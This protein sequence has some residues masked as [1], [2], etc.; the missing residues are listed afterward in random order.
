MKEFCTGEDSHTVV[1]C[2]EPRAVGEDDRY[3]LRCT[4][5]GKEETD[6][7]RRPRQTSM[8]CGENK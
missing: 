3:H 6:I 5:C 7:A 8:M 2:I 1:T 4:K